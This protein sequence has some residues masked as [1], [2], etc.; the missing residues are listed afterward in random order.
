MDSHCWFRRE[1]G[2]APGGRR[3]GILPAGARAS[4]PCQSMAGAAMAQGR[5]AGPALRPC[6]SSRPAAHPVR[7]GKSRKAGERALR[8][9]LLAAG[10]NRNRPRV[11]HYPVSVIDRAETK[12]E[13]DGAERFARARHHGGDG[14]AAR[15]VGAPST[16]GSGVRHS[17]PRWPESAGGGGVGWL[18]RK[19]RLV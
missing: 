2:R 1:L 16:P 11:T 7:R 5:S 9:V 4:R 14:H 13:E 6:G 10:A 18:A 8:Y 17:R 12:E 15:S 19:R 3:G